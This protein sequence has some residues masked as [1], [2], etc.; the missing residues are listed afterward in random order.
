MPDSD[1]FVLKKAEANAAVSPEQIERF[2]QLI[3]LPNNMLR[4]FMEF[5]L[6]VTGASLPDVAPGPEMGVLIKAMETKNFEALM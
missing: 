2:G 5:R 6:T 3:G 1:A 4:A